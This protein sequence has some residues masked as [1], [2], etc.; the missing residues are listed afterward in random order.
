[1]HALLPLFAFVAF[2]TSAHAAPST[3]VTISVVGTS[4][5]HGHIAAL[6]WLAGYLEN[7]R[8]VRA[9]TGGAV[10]LLDAGDMF[11][12]TLESNLAEGAPVV[13]AYN[14]LGYS[15]AAIG[16]HEFDFGPAGPAP[17]PVGP[18]D[19]PRGA[20]KARASE[21]H[22]PFLASNIVDAKTG[23]P[24]GWPNVKPSTIIDAAGIK[25]GL[26]GAV[27]AAT[28]GSALPAN[29]KGLKFL[30]L[31]KSIASEARTLR[32]H[33][34]KMVLAVVHEGGECTDFTAPDKLDSCV[35][36]SKI[37][38][39]ARELPKGAVDAI[40]AGHTH[41]AVAQR[42]AAVPIIQAYCNGRAFGRVDLTVDRK[43]G[44]V[45]ASHLEAPHDLCQSG[46]GESCRAGDYEGEPV[47][48]SEE[49]V[50]LNA[51]AFAA[52]RQK[53]SESLNIKVLHRLPHSR[54]QETALGNL[55]ADL[56][57]AA[58]P[59]DVA[60]INGGGMRAAVPAGPLTYGR[61]YETFPF[62]NAFASVRLPASELRRLLGRSLSRSESLVSLSGLRVRATC[63]KS[64][65]EVALSRPDGIPVRDDEMLTLITTDYLA[66]GGDGF[67]AGATVDYEVGL[68][69]R[70]VLAETLQKRGGV[71]DTSDRSLFD[72]AHPRIALPGD[73]PVQCGP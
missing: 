6:P 41:E 19:D 8:K 60:M 17:S 56:M 14:A 70:D 37:F 73:V 29:V 5:L 26:V 59:S 10:V 66:T 63:E 45:V 32:A 68:P 13:R 31:A 11:Q 72:P 51:P 22:F 62:D 36:Q 42:V 35:V 16:N 39:I 69:I 57:R 50:Q 15:A 40:V 18:D 38:A 2:A 30:P 34:A 33:G 46:S 4:D 43:S 48:A 28:P 9:R 23:K 7:L 47:R 3:R 65:L 55:L 58:R 24:V 67:F 27:T 25:I 71:L 53:G 1:M 52:A 21:A 61:L 49:V 20:L 12:G 54:K 64:G 44:K